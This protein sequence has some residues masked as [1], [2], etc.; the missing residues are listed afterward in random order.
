VAQSCEH[1]RFRSAPPRLGYSRQT[2]A[3]RLGCCAGLHQALFRRV[4]DE[5]GTRTPHLHSSAIGYTLQVFRL[6]DGKRL[7]NSDCRF[8][9]FLRL[10]TCIRA[11]GIPQ[12]DMPV[13][14]AG[15]AGLHRYPGKASAGVFKYL[16]N[17]EKCMKNRKRAGELFGVE[18]YDPIDAIT[19]ACGI[20]D[21]IK[22]EWGEAWSEHDQRVRA[23]LSEVL[24]DF[25]SDPKIEEWWRNLDE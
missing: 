9:A 23:G 2:S 12:S 3:R 5:V 19:H 14:R 25:A 6:Y 8:P 7:H 16:E 11:M 4:T 24:M 15:L 17:R 22:G 21:V 1:I 18:P 10:D 13:P 20:L